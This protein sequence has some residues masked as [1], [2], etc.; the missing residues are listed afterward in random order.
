MSDVLQELRDLVVRFRDERDWEQFHRIKELIA[1][2]QIEAAEL[3]E[4]FLWKDHAAAEASLQKADFRQRVA[5]E[6]ADVQTFLLYLAEATQIDLAQA[7]RDKVAKNAQKY[8]VEKARGSA[9]K[10]NEL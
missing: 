8:P 10:Y 3:A 4:L 6:L 2:M 5:D 7:V 9:K 1:G